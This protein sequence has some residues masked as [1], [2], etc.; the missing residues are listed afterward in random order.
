[1]HVKK[2]DIVMVISGKERGRTGKVLKVFPKKN[3][4]IV[5]KL[6]MVK[7]HMRA[8]GRDIG[9][10][11]DKEAPIH[12]SNVL[13]LCTKCGRGVRTRRVFKEDQPRKRIRE[14]VKC[15]QIFS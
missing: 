13:I 3:K 15:G 12:I 4:V 9:G 6:N 10:I 8:R 1:M 11:V 5:E 14:C 2:N 7:R